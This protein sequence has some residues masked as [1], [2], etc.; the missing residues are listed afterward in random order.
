M[1]LASRQTVAASLR[2][3]LYATYSST[4]TRLLK[5]RDFSRSSTRRFSAG[6]SSST[7]SESTRSVSRAAS[8]FES[9]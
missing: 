2:R 9:E 3:S 8:L 6:V 7:C 5:R 4:G 1:A